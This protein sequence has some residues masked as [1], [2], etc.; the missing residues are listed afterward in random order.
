MC[1][2]NPLLASLTVGRQ[3]IAR[4]VALAPMSGVT[5]LPFRSLAHRLGAG[6]VVSEMVASE[7]LVRERPDILRKARKPDHVPFVL[8]LAGREARWM[9]EGARMAEAMGADIIDINMG[10]P[11]REVTGALA[12]SALMRDP[13]HAL[14]LIDAVVG[15]VRIPVTLKMRMG[16]DHKSLNAPEIAAR[17]E[18]AGVQLIT[19]HA[20][21]RCQFFKER[22]D[23]AFVRKVKA[24]V[25]VPVIVNGD[26]ASI[27][28]AVRSLSLSGA[29]GVMIGRG[30]YGQP[31]L[32]GRV[33]AFLASGRDPGLPG[34]RQRAACAIEPFEAML[35]HYGME[36]GLRNARKH[37]GWYVERL[38]GSGTSGKAWRSRLCQADGHEAVRDGLNGLF[39]EAPEAAR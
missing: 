29:D 25:R 26:I 10:C 1:V 7:P 17:A 20:R 3:C 2:R 31:W 30:A 9:A 24:A 35:S 22:A 27:E 19:V 5:D 8:Q 16:W 14:S 13:D 34:L 38:I 18:A 36:L 37:L 11:A 32:P 15:S 21:T 28:D 33:A 12:G 6:I 23:W 4:P 39:C